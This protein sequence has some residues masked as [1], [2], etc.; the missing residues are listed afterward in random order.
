MALK[1]G[2]NLI[3]CWKDNQLFQP[4]ISLKYHLCH[5]FYLFTFGMYIIG[6][7]KISFLS[8][9]K[10]FHMNIKIILLIKNLHRD[11]DRNIDTNFGNKGNFIKCFHPGFFRSCVLYP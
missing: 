5:M 6:A 8:V 3:F 1:L 11:S 4:Y 2:F 9:F 10:F 7:S